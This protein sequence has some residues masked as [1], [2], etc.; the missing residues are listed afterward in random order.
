MWVAFCMTLVTCCSYMLGCVVHL[1][2]FMSM[3]MIGFLPCVSTNVFIGAS[4]FHLSGPGIS[5]VLHS[6]VIFCF[7]C[8]QS[9]AFAVF[10]I[11]SI[12]CS[13]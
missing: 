8:A 12:D 6:S 9:F 10:C 3:V 7:M 13:V 1:F 11:V 2:V 4:R 5:F